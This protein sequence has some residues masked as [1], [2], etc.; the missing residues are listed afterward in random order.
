MIATAGAGCLQFSPMGWLYAQP[1]A[2][3]R[4]KRLIVIFLRGAVDGLNVVIPYRDERYYQARR[5]IAI[6]RPGDK[7]GSLPLTDQFALHPSLSM[8]MPLWRNKTLSFVH[9]CGSPDPS[10]SHFD[11]QDYMESGVPGVSSPSQGWMNRLMSVLPKQSQNRTAVNF[12]ETQSVIFLGDQKIDS[13][14]LKS[15]Q[16]SMPLDRPQVS[17]A[18]EK[19]YSGSDEL[20]Q[21][22]QQGLNTREELMEDMAGITNEKILKEMREANRGAKQARAYG[23]FGKILAKVITKQP[24]ISLGFFAIGGWDTHANQGQA[25]GQLANH[26]QALGQGLNDLATDLGDLYLDT[27]VVVMSEFGRTVKEN[28]SGGTDHGHGNAMWLLGG[29][30]SGGNVLG[31]WPGLASSSL[32][33]GRDL[34]VTTDYRDVIG[35][36]T[37]K[38]LGLSEEHVQKVF[39]QHAFR[40]ILV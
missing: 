18:F 2:E 22:F 29:G 33:E 14:P 40:K 21:A 34:A 3:I 6:P 19:L 26:L 32:Y 27:T 13:L 10:R 17:S 37:Q 25:T 31:D 8:L 39:P 36:I 1:T 16:R 4:N 28:G 15:V 9:A 11:A 23:H 30:V 38:N 24:Q 7:N 12:S 5:T 35:S 20:S